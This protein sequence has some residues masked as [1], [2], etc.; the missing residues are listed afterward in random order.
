MD[1]GAAIGAGRLSV[2]RDNGRGDPYVG[3]V[4]L[5]TGEIAEDITAYLL[6]SEQRPAAVGLAANA[7]PQGMGRSGGF[8]VEPMPDASDETLAYL[9]AR[10]GGFP[11]L[12]FFL[13]EGFTAAQIIELLMGDVDVR[14]LERQEVLSPYLLRADDLSFDAG[15]KGSPKLAKDLRIQ[16]ECHF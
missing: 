8:L 4:E 5:R 11:G 16:L 14:Y 3:Q 6:Y 15:E 10:V 13:Q 1:L 12:D 9:E 7:T 2:V